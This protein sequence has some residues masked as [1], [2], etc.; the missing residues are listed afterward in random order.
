MLHLMSLRFRITSFAVILFFL[1]AMITGGVVY[2]RQQA[3]ENRLLEDLVWAVYQFDREVR[4]LRLTLSHTQDGDL[5]ELLTRYE[6]LYSRGQLF[7]RG[8]IARSMAAIPAIRQPLV[9]ALTAI[10][11]MEA[12]FRALGD[13]ELSLTPAFR[14]RLEAKFQALQ[15]DVGTTLVNTHGYVA[16]LRVEE[17]QLLLR[18]YAVVLA[19]VL[20]MMGS[21]GVLVVSLLRQARERQ[22]K[23][24]QLEVRTRELEA[25]RERAEEASRAK[26][27]F[28]AVMS[29]EIRTPLNGVVGVADLL[30]G[31]VSGPRGH[32]LLQ[33]LRDSAMGL[34]VVINDV[35]DFTKIEAGS[36][37]LD[38][39]P[40]SLS[41]FLDQLCAGY[42]T[43]EKA[44]GLRFECD[45][46]AALPDWVSGDVNRLRQIAMNLLNNAFKFTEAGFVRLSVFP[47]DGAIRFDIRDTGCGIEPA[48]QTRLFAPFSQVDSSIARRHEGT[49]LGLAIC[50]RLVTAMGGEIGLDS[51]PGLG[52]LFWFRVPLP[53]VA[54]GEI[55][56]TVCEPASALSRHHLLIVEDNP[57]NQALT[58]A[59]LEYLGQSADIVDNGEAALVALAQTPYDLVLMDIQMPRLD[60]LETTRRWRARET[61]TRLPIVAVTANVMPADRQHCLEAG[62]DDMICKPFTRAD[63]RRLLGRFL[64]VAKGPGEVREAVA[65]EEAPAASAGPPLIDPA[66]R[67]E[68]R[69]A[70][71]PDVLEGLLLT[72]L[73]RLTS[74]LSRFETL[75]AAE[76]RAG[77]AAEAHSLKGASSS[78]GCT[79]M[80]QAAAELERIAAD[81]PFAT[82]AQRVAELRR[83]QEATSE[84]LR[85]EGLLPA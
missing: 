76:D 64:G 73:E 22:F 55:D 31:E 4:E 85:E 35:L 77:I 72:Y 68:L 14:Q 52:S 28:M 53:R 60:G 46:D 57:V 13:G 12:D 45:I 24:E 10:H 27:E 82:L 1:S 23:T 48:M 81:T 11:D 3:V 20:L 25:A 2:Q 40:F 17:R 16:S 26:S 61:G 56:E 74:R 71:A 42:R 58:Q 51:H 75:L 66:T 7:S 9:K 33:T 62:M 34:Q 78:L 43:R 70:L 5:D 15:E 84:A 47:D 8:E 38:R 41:A 49:G 59:M 37:D 19:M 21:G 50:Q 32:D 36:L 54:E 30:D 69:D 29:H 63:L 18:L 80:A 39:R 83:L 79:A 67:D 44:T 6:I 65:S